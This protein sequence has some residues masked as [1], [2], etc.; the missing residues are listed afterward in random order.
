MKIS[1][2]ADYGMRAVIYIARQPKDKRNPI[3][4][5]AESE[6]IP[7]DFLA[8]ILKDLTRSDILRSYQGVHGGY[9]LARSAS[10]IS[11]LDIV[12]AMDGQ[13]GLDLCVRTENG[14]DKKHSAHQVMYP[15]F[16]GLQKQVRT[17]FKSA[18]VAKLIKGKGRR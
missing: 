1:R 3:D 15:F 18:T 9:Q 7:R 16:T 8:K 5:I 2:K 14:C 6:C 17:A 10:Q 4:V 12:E 11:L 13:L